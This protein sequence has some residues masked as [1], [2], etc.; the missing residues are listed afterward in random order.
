VTFTEDEMREDLEGVIQTAAPLAVVFPWFALGGD[1]QT[2]PGKLVSVKDQNRVH[3]YVITPTRTYSIRQNPNCLRQFFGY[4]ISGLHW[5]ET[6][7]RTSNS[8]LIHAAEIR[9]ICQQFANK[10]DLPK[11]IRRIVSEGRELDFQI[12]LKQYG[13]RLLHRSGGEITIEQC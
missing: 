3:G 9:A 8:D 12:N 6:G 5:Y 10:N 2:W 13:G 11:S 1:E 7:K 4:R